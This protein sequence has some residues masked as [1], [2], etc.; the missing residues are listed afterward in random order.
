MSGLFNF[1]GHRQQQQ[2]QQNYYYSQGGSNNSR[3]NT[4]RQQQQKQQI[5][6]Q[7]DKEFDLIREAVAQQQAAEDK[8]K[9]EGNGENESNPPTQDQPSSTTTNRS[10]T[11]P[12]EAAH[13]A[14]LA[15]KLEIDS[16]DIALYVLA[17]KLGCAMPFTVQRKEWCQGLAALGVDSLPTMK[18][19]IPALRAETSHPKSFKEFYFWIFMWL[20]HSEMVKFLQVETAVTMWP[21][22]FDSLTTGHTFPVL[23]E[24]LEFWSTQKVGKGVTK[25]VWRQT[26]DFTAVDIYSDLSPTNPKGYDEAG[27]WPSVMDEF[28]SWARK[29]QSQQKKSVPPPISSSSEAEGKTS[30]I[31]DE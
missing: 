26:F 23:D 14:Y 3:F 10:D 29:K 28:V 13:L 5:I 20:R 17:W 1:H 2:Q 8:K 22:F 9:Q 7:L 6:I 12:L 24:W 19:I 11:D 30:Y 25:D 16:D 27:S 31:C 18:S 21:L 4:S 15:E